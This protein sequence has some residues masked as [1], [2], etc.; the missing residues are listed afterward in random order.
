M[1]DK[2]NVYRAVWPFYKT[3]IAENV[4]ME[5]AKKTIAEQS[6]GNVMISGRPEMQEK[7]IIERNNQTDK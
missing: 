1:T 3:L 2:F 4:T 6:P 5:D 7:F